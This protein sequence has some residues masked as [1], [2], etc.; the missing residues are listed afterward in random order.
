MYIGD[1]EEIENGK[2]IYRVNYSQEELDTLNFLL[3]ANL[4]MTEWISIVTKYD[5]ILHCVAFS[6]LDNKEYDLRKVFGLD[7]NSPFYKIDENA[8]IE[9]QDL[10]EIEHPQNTATNMNAIIIKDNEIYF[11]KPF[12]P[13]EIN[14]W[15][16]LMEDGITLFVITYDSLEDMKKGLKKIDCIYNKDC[17]I[18]AFIGNG[19]I[20]DVY[21]CEETET[22]YEIILNEK[23]G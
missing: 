8:I 12:E 22:G 7:K 10:F 18:Y 15:V 23:M 1:I 16:E 6:E 21:D 2:T 9:Y 4:R 3:G 19:N 14:Y 17:E 20:Y 11:P 5:K 13:I